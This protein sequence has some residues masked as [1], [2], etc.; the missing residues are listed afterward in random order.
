MTD[1]VVGTVKAGVER[2]ERTGQELG[3]HPEMLAAGPTAAVAQAAIS[4]ETK[5]AVAEVKSATA[6]AGGGARGAA[7]AVNNLYNPGAPVVDA[8]EATAVAAA[9]G[10][11]RATAKA[12]ANVGITAA[13]GFLQVLG[14]VEGAASLGGAIKGG[15]APPLLEGSGSAPAPGNGGVSAAVKKFVADERGGVPG[16]LKPPTRRLATEGDTQFRTEADAL[17]EAAKRWGIDPITLE[18]MPMYGKNPNLTGAKGGPWYIVSGLNAEA[19]IIEFDHHAH[20]HVYLDTN[21][22]ERPH[23]HGPDKEHLT[24]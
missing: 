24:Y 22:F 11:V 23:F 18:S 12:G 5:H 10:D 14:A 4:G 3:A 6:A 2:I 20:G 1:V 16:T 7:V 19:K 13:S 17:A 21:E 8:V 9:K 15:A